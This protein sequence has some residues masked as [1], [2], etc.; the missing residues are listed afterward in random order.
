MGV[1]GVVGVVGG[2]HP[3]C[4]ETA[5]SKHAPCTRQ[6]PHS[7]APTQPR[8]HTPTVP[9]ETMAAQRGSDRGWCMFYC[10]RDLLALACATAPC[11]CPLPSLP[12]PGSR[13]ARRWWW[14]SRGSVVVSVPN[15]VGCG[16]QRQTLAPWPSVCRGSVKWVG[17]VCRL[18]SRGPTPPFWSQ[19]AP[20]GTFGTPVGGVCTQQAGHDGH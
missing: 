3:R 18:A 6:H 15:A 20:L 10:F 8:T 11:P 14:G 4:T 2:A 1:V 12:K 16:C 13:V 5:A 19:H 9:L 7:H 17:G